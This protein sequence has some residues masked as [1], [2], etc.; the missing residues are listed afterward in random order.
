[1]GQM[2]LSKKQVNQNLPNMTDFKSNYRSIW[3]FSQETWKNIKAL[4]G[5]V[6]ER[7]TVIHITDM[8]DDYQIQKQDLDEER[9]ISPGLTVKL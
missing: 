7:S 5:S 3:N 2:R 9:L 4:L 8:I 6:F 1:M